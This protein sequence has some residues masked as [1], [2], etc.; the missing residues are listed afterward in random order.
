MKEAF[1][2]LAHTQPIYPILNKWKQ[3]LSNKG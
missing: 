3:N 2:A 1:Q